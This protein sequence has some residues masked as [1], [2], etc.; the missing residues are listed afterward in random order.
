MFPFF[1]YIQTGS[2]KI[3][4]HISIPIVY[5][6]IKCVYMYMSYILWKTLVFECVS[7]QK[8]MK[9]DSLKIKLHI[10]YEEVNI[11]YA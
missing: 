10:S 1:V 4:F 6:F 9:I 3:S 2:N 5:L 8:E 7:V 11:R